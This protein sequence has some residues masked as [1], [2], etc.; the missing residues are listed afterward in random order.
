M[1]EDSKIKIKGD[2]YF[3]LH[4][5]LVEGIKKCKDRK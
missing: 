5:F 1:R 3:F 2:I 4:V